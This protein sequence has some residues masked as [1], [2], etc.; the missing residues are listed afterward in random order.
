MTHPLSYAIAAQQHPAETTH[1]VQK[2]ARRLGN[3][4]PVVFKW[5]YYYG[6]QLDIFGSPT[7][8]FCALVA[9]SGRYTSRKTLDA[10][11]AVLASR[12]A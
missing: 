6:E 3:S 7:V 8:A 2:L 12:P 10:V 11:P 1:L 9:Q 5:S 4:N